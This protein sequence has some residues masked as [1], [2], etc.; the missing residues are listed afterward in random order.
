[1]SSLAERFRAHF[2]RPAAVLADE[3]GIRAFEACGECGYPLI[4]YEEA[5]AAEV[6]EK[7]VQADDALAG[8]LFAH[9][10]SEVHFQELGVRM[11]AHR[12]FG[13]GDAL[14]RIIV[15]QH[16]HAVFGTLDVCLDAVSAHIQS[17]IE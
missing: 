17:G 7:R 11:V 16:Q 9:E 14:K 10:A 13:M 1:M 3:K 6:C 5:A 4:A 12:A 2:G 15:M 8:E